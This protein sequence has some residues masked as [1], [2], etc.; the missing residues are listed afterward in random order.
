MDSYHELA[1]AVIMQ[2][3]KDYRLALKQ[4]YLWP[5][6]EEFQQDVAELERFF[7]SDWFQIL[8]DLDGP[9][10]MKRVQKMVGMEVVA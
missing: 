3:V 6:R 2:A 1:N 7:I 10:L 4:L 8:S 5:D 9:L